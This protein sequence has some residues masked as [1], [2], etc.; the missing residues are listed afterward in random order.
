MQHNVLRR[1]VELQSDR[2]VAYY[3]PLRFRAF[4]GTIG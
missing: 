3:E 1:T 2:D 4:Q